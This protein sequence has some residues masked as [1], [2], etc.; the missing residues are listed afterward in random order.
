M[1]NSEWWVAERVMRFEHNG[2]LSHGKVLLS[3]A[4]CIVLYSNEE[5]GTFERG[6]FKKKKRKGLSDQGSPDRVGGK[7]GTENAGGGALRSSWQMKVKSPTRNPCVWA[8][9]NPPQG[10]GPGQPPRLTNHLPC[11]IDAVRAL[12][13]YSS[14]IER[15]SQKDPMPDDATTTGAPEN[16][17]DPDATLRA[18]PR[19]LVEPVGASCR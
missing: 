9:Q 14:A 15:P 2:V 4:I 8:T 5:R 10:L 6:A 17:S 18:Q 11:C 19:Q 3:I 13:L 16:P 7:L 12:R 1:V